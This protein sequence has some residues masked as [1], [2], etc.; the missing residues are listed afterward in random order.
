[1]TGLGF[2][3]LA[4]K[5][6]FWLKAQKSRLQLSVHGHVRADL[7]CQ[8]PKKKEGAEL[9]AKL[10]R[11]PCRQ[12]AAVTGAYSMAVSVRT[13]FLASSSL[14]TSKIWLQSATPK[15]VARSFIG[16]ASMFVCRKTNSAGIN[17]SMDV[18]FYT[19]KA[20]TNRL[21]FTLV[22]EWLLYTRSILKV[23]ET[24]NRF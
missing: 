9:N 20:P 23:L 2:S 11:E 6:A 5:K 4:Q 22:A 16:K 19:S 14:Y 21:R 17:A 13:S 1:M 10:D 24:Q 12:G 15:T 18:I 3:F 8:I 7:G